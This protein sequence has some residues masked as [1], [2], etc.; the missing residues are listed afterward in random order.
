[1]LKNNVAERAI[2]QIFVLIDKLNQAALHHLSKLN[3]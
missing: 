2:W 3:V 1:M